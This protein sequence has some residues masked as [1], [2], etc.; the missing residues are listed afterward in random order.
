MGS[1]AWSRRRQPT[2]KPLSK[3]QNDCTPLGPLTEADLLR[4]IAR[5]R[6]AMMGGFELEV[7]EVSSARSSDELR[8]L[9]ERA[10]R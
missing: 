10:V 2:R 3:A 4:E 5:R 9:T 6:V 7:I 1:T 8:G